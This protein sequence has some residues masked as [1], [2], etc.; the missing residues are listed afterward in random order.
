MGGQLGDDPVGEGAHH[1][2]AAHAGEDVRHVLQALAPVLRDL[3]G[4]EVDRVPAELVHADGERHARAQRGLVEHQC[5]RLPLERARRAAGPAS[6][7][8][9]VRLLEQPERPFGLEAEQ[10]DEVSGTTHMNRSS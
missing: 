4:A 5:R 7:P 1:D 2:E 8:Q 6:G 9:V 10:V 3:Q